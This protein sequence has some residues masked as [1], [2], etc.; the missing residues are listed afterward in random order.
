MPYEDAETKEVISVWSKTKNWVPA[1][2]IMII[3]FSL[4]SMKGTTVDEVG[5]GRHAYQV[6]GHFLLY[7]SL[8]IAFFKA[9]KNYIYSPL[10]TILY[11]LSDEIHQTFVPGRNFQIFDL[12]VDSIGILLALIFIW[13]IVQ[14][15]SGILKNWLVS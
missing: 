3:I 6:N 14:K 12:G 5:L 7:F 13:I 15:T 11:G 2:F 1:I 10:Y 4:S 8:C 9:T